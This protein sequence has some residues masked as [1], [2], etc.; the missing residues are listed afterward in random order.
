MHSPRWAAAGQTAPTWAAAVPPRPTLVLL[1]AAPGSETS[2][3]ASPSS[4]WP[5]GQPELLLEL[6]SFAFSPS[7]IVCGRFTAVGRWIS[8]TR[9]EV[10][11]LETVYIRRQMCRDIRP[12]GTVHN[13]RKPKSEAVDTIAATQKLAVVGWCAFGGP[14]A[15][16][17]SEKRGRTAL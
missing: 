17:M 15:R 9:H 5:H 8:S 14:D 7:L 3:E 4:S 12:V 11:I 16:N 2:R 10:L 13:K 6:A 1:A